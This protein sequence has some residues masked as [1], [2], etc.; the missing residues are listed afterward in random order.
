MCP[1]TWDSPGAPDIQSGTAFPG[2][3]L[4]AVFQIFNFRLIY[5]KWERT[6][7]R[8]ELKVETD[9]YW[10]FFAKIR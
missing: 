7:S 6:Q 1:A 3:G 8:I 9:D 10:A 5:K 2:E 4:I